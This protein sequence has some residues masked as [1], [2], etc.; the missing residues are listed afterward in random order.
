MSPHHLHQPQFDL[1]TTTATTTKATTTRTA[2]ATPPTPP[3]PPVQ[4]NGINFNRGLSILRNAIF[5]HGLATKT[6]KINNGGDA[7]DY[8]LL[9]HSINSQSD[10]FVH[11]LQKI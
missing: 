7:K 3:P 1:I 11:S 6:N 5:G 8:K 2:T 9:N 10:Q 4:T